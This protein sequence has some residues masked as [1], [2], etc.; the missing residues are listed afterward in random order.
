MKPLFLLSVLFA[1][2]AGQPLFSEDIDRIQE[3][4]QT[5]QATTAAADP[6]DREPTELGAF[7]APRVRQPDG[8]IGFLNLTIGAPRPD[9]DEAEF[10]AQ[11]V[12]Q[13]RQ[14]APNLRVVELN[15][16]YVFNVGR[17]S[18]WTF[19]DEARNIRAQLDAIVAA[20]HRS[21]GGGWDGGP[22][23]RIDRFDYRV[24]LFVVEE[25]YRPSMVNADEL[26]TFWR[27]E[28]ADRQSNGLVDTFR[29][30]FHVQNEPIELT[31]QLQR[32]PAAQAAKLNELLPRGRSEFAD[33]GE[34]LS[35]MPW[36]NTIWSMKRMLKEEVLA[37]IAPTVA[38]KTA[39]S[40][41]LDSQLILLAK[42]KQTGGESKEA[43]E[44][45]PPVTSAELPQ[46]TTRRPTTTTE[47]PTT[48]TSTE[49]SSTWTPVHLTTLHTARPTAVRFFSTAAPAVYRVL[50]TAAPSFIS[51]WS[52]RPAVVTYAPPPAA[53]FP[54]G[55]VTPYAPANTMS[56]F[57][58]KTTGGFPWGQGV[59][60]G[61][62]IEPPTTAQSVNLNPFVPGVFQPINHGRRRRSVEQRA[63]GERVDE[64]PSVGEPAGEL[65]PTDLPNT[66]LPSS[67]ERP[68]ES[69]RLPAS[70]QKAEFASSI[71]TEDPK[72]PDVA[73]VEKPAVQPSASRK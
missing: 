6:L 22:N 15:A 62:E 70:K 69:T 67:T 68:Q 40:G 3:L 41:D 8:R 21:N 52:P 25:N 38:N 9:R 4:I 50:H 72:T 57:L 54:P 44:R 29:W 61:V 58:P 19:L 28:R 35:I 34:S 26:S 45:E 7:F 24:F 36:L 39:A 73:R 1:A 17:D 11:A 60:A 65:P 51:G 5:T 32:F 30:A 43:D 63:V 42:I 66:W 10:Y 12:R 53:T 27:A 13:L 18:S 47:E 59:F 46:T 64:Q 2:A 56:G 16:S 37:S 33:V 14:L 48:T 31:V 55:V 23:V 20:F 49:R 71:Q